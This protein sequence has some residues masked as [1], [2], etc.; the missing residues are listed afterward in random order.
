M[1][2][3]KILGMIITFPIA[4]PFIVIFLFFICVESWLDVLWEWFI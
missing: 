3:L 2:Y 4:V 1:K